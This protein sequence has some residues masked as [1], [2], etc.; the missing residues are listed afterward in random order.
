MSDDQRQNRYTAA[1]GIAEAAVRDM[2]D[3]ALRQLA[4]S[5]V[6]RDVLVDQQYP[7]RQSSH[8][9]GNSEVSQPGNMAPIPISGYSK[10][11][12]DRI[13]QHLSIDRAL[14]NSVFEIWDERPRLAL[15]SS[16]LPSAR[17]RATQEIALVLCSAYEALDLDPPD[18]D[19]V[20]QE[21]ERYDRYDSANFAKTLGA[22]EGRLTPKGPP[23][24]KKKAL[25]ISV[26]GREAAAIVLQ[27][28]AGEGNGS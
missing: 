20:R 16:R 12:M 14:T 17:L 15:P 11:P 9:V 23:R 7:E 27:R 6:L 2:S 1:I 5:E 10:D 8:P 3:D 26:P 22:M 24:A 13:A 21:C 18:T 28:W 25:I 4:F 19:V